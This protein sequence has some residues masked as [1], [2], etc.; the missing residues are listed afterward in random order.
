MAEDNKTTLTRALAGRRASPAASVSETLSAFNLI[1][2]GISPATL[3]MLG[4][5][6]G[7]SAAAAVTPPPTDR[8][9]DTAEVT[10]SA[11]LEQVDKVNDHY[12]LASQ[13]LAALRKETDSGGDLRGKADA[14][15]K[16][17]AGGGRLAS[18]KTA[19]GDLLTAG[20]DGLAWPKAVTVQA[21]GEKK[22]DAAGKALSPEIVQNEQSALFELSRAMVSDTRVVEKLRHGLSNLRRTRQ[23]DLARKEAELA[24]LDKEINAARKTLATLDRARVEALDDHAVAQRLLAEHWA[25][26]EQKWA[27]RKRIL[28]GHKGLFYVR[29]RETP[30]SQTLPDPLEL[31]YTD[32]DDL[33]P[34][35]ASETT[36]LPEDL[37][38]FL[39][40][41]Y[42]IPVGDWAGLRDQAALLP[43]RERVQ[44][45]VGQ[46][47]ERLARKSASPGGSALAQ[48][49]GPLQQQNLGLAR[50][51]SKRGFSPNGAL[52]EVQRQARDLLSL[53]DLMTGPPHK[54]RKPV[55]ALHQQLGNAAACLVQRLRGIS[56]GLRAQW[57]EMAETDLPILPTPSRWPGLAQAE[58]ADFNGV[59]TLLELIGW[60]CR[61]LQPEAS[62]AA[63]TVLSNYLRACLLHA[64]GDD[65]DQAMR[66]QVSTLPGRFR[67]GELMRVK[68]NREAAPGA[69][70][71]LM[72]PDQRVVS[73]LR[74]EDSDE[75]GAVAVI[76][77]VLAPEETLT[78]AF[79]V[80]VRTQGRRG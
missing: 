67:T 44:A 40:A 46:R 58:A 47:R 24:G 4:K 57:A 28:E 3:S 35:C 80:S 12:L 59:R 77:Q 72:S 51:L 53:D 21:P 14:Y 56:P 52:S 6:G 71:T 62:G 8:V 68:L 29:V 49:L 17:H 10:K 69:L 78:T 32:A 55:Q 16:Q 76:T 73:S 42:D 18:A 1:S 65:P 66:G 60:W 63:L 61:Q 39:E 27:E 34:G 74:V 45:L 13:G 43:G 31:R 7:A 64:V 22:T 37:L 48:R 41:V 33:V 23:A 70:L 20:G 5:L 11:T 2:A 9:Y 79:Q 19:L 30:V 75:Q 38:P 15:L 26:V 54:L 50:D 36:E 25:E